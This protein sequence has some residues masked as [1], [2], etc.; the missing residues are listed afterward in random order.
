[1]HFPAPDAPK[2]QQQH[3]LLDGDGGRRLGEVNG[4]VDAA[5]ITGL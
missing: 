2:V 5:Q 3:I 1:L 4:G